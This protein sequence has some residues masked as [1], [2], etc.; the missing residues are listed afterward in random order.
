MSFKRAMNPAVF[1]VIESIY[2][3]SVDRAPLAG[4]VFVIGGREFREQGDDPP[5]NLHLQLIAGLD[6][7]LTPDAGRED[8]ASSFIDCDGHKRR[9]KGLAQEA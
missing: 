3:K 5:R 1:D 4:C 8:L 7:G 2:Y 6:A 9:V